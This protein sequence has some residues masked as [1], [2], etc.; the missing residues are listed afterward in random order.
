[1]EIRLVGLGDV[2]VHQRIFLPEAAYSDVD[3]R[4]LRKRDGTELFIVAPP[5]PAAPAELT[6]TDLRLSMTFQR[7]QDGNPVVLSQAGSTVSESA[8]LGV[9]LK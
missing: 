3:F 6:E 5:Q 1:M 7:Q 9:P 4:V 2:I 8:A